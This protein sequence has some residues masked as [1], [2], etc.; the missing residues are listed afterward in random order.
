MVRLGLVLL[1]SSVLASAAL[2]DAIY[3]VVGPD[4]KVSYSSVP[5]AETQKST[6]LRMDVPAPEASKNVPASGAQ[7]SAPKVPKEVQKE[8]QNSSDAAAEPARGPLQVAKDLLGLKSATTLNGK[9][10]PKPAGKPL[11]SQPGFGQPILF[12]KVIGCG[13]CDAARQYMNEKK[14]AFRGIDVSTE[15]G[16]RAMNEVDRKSP[17]PLLIASGKK[18]SGFSSDAYDELLRNYV[19]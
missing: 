19:K 1:L 14:I 16:R 7:K 6:Q 12:Y 13:P 17:L 8:V 5:P 10:E 2:A 18:A 4:G 11:S 9:S 15:D 3:K